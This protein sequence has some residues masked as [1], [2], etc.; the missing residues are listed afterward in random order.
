MN[1]PTLLP[2][3]DAVTGFQVNTVLQ[4]VQ[5]VGQFLVQPD[6]DAA[7]PHKPGGSMDGGA[8]D[9][10]TVTFIKACEKLDLILEDKGRWDMEVQQLLELQL[11]KLMRD[12]MAFLAAQTA[13]SLALN[14]PTYLHQPTIV[15]AGDGNFIALLGDPENPA[16][17]GIG[18]SP[19]EAC[20]DFDKSFTGQTTPNQIRWLKEH[21]DKPAPTPK[22]PR[23][24][25]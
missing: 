10:A 4:I 22:K 24:K 14:S 13:A 17:I 19:A 25:K 8:R 5:T 21:P 15:N 3:R 2:S 18:G 6:I 20:A 11:A 23:K 16:C 7:N 12:Q 1:K 9:S